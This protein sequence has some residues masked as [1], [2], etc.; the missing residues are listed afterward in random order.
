MAAGRGAQDVRDGE[1]HARRRGGRGRERPDHLGGRAW[2]GSADSASVP[3]ARAGL[4]PRRK[5]PRLHGRDR[6]RA[7]AGGL[8]HPRGGRRHGGDDAVR[9]GAR[10]PPGSPRTAAR[11]P[12][13]PRAG[14]RPVL[15]SLGGGRRGRDITEPLSGAGERAGSG[16]RRQPHRHERQ[17]RRLHPVRAVRAG[18]PR[19]PG[20]RRDRDGRARP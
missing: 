9:A 17:S 16:L 20:Q 7:D 10:R 8:V 6:G 5:L 11:R 15:A 12:A 2:Q 18:V 3:Q 13:R 14:A 19:G 1:V 4:P